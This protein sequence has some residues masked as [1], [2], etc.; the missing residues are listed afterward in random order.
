LQTATTLSI[1]R[2]GT[3]EPVQAPPEVVFDEVTKG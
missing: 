3:P 2:G 1:M